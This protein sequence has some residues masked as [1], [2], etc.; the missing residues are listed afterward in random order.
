MLPIFRNKPANGQ[1]PSEAFRRHF[2][3]KK[4]HLMAGAV[5]IFGL[6]LICPGRIRF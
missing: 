3:V 4:P 1:M 2:P 6:K 5:S